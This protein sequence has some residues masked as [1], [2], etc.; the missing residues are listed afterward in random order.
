[1]SFRRRDRALRTDGTS[2]I[3]YTAVNALRP[4]DNYDNYDIIE[5]PRRAKRNSINVPVS[6]TKLATL[7]EGFHHLVG[8][9][10]WGTTGFFEEPGGGAGGRPRRE[11]A[12]VA[13]RVAHLA[14]QSIPAG[15]TRFAGGF[16]SRVR[17]SGRA[18]A[19]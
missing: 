16:F 18:D 17:V 1:M 6:T 15:N 5:S 19:A 13:A 2:F 9:R 7:R 3:Q 12:R 11:G 8:E 14:A 10:G 4:N